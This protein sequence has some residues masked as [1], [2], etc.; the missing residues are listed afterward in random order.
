MSGNA[1]RPGQPQGWRAPHPGN[2]PPQGPA[3]SPQGHQP[4]GQQ[5]QPA[6]QTGAPKRRSKAPLI[7]TAIIVAI[8]LVVAVAVVLTVGGAKRGTLDEQWQ[9]V[10]QLAPNGEVAMLE[11]R[12]GPAAK[13]Q[14][15]KKAEYL[16]LAWVDDS[17]LQYRTEN[18]GNSN[19]ETQRVK[20]AGIKNHQVT[21]AQLQQFKD[22]IATVECD[23]EKFRFGRMVFLPDGTPMF[24]SGC[25]I[26][27]N[28]EGMQPTKKFTLEGKTYDVKPATIGEKLELF[29]LLESHME[30]ELTKIVFDFT[31]EI[32]GFSCLGDAEYFVPDCK[33]HGLRVLD[34]VFPRMDERVAA[35]ADPFR[36][37]DKV[38]DKVPAGLPAGYLDVQAIN[39]DAV[40]KVLDMLKTKNLYPNQSALVFIVQRTDKS[41]AFCVSIGAENL[42]IL[43]ETGR[44]IN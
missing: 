18:P 21:D 24:T 4:L 35:D 26:G 2:R 40:V 27:Y 22:Y 11:W 6:Q 31:G 7:I 1:P 33:V 44:V 37:P 32:S 16:D 28:S 43:D 41:S 5:W 10:K 12:Q 8:A 34:T 17:S 14:Y 19:V 29:K 23:A 3:M 20:P 36:W 39:V 15:T 38:K 9:Q 30:V 25:Q 42:F 13:D